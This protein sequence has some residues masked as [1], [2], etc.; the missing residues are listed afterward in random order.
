MKK[1]VDLL[2]LFFSEY[3]FN[4]AIFEIKY[5]LNRPSTR[6]NRHA[7]KS[8]KARTLLKNSKKL[9]LGCGTIH[10]ENFINIDS[11]KLST[12]DFR[13][14]LKELNKYFPKGEIQEI[15]LCHILEHFSWRIV[16]DYLRNFYDLLQKGGIIRISVPDLR[17]IFEIINEPLADEE[18]KLM[19]GVLMGG[20][21]HK[22]N[23]HYSLFWREYLEKELENIGFINIKEYVSRPHIYGTNI[24][25][26][27]SEAGFNFNKNGISLNIQAE[28]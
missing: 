26:A 21:D 16:Q 28:K 9:H 4:R 12:I 27:S 5:L 14:N 24:K 20:Q 8:H 3:G 25:D 10:I 17:K 15:Y 1:L 23:V 13:C 11:V 19:Q 2:K 18:L 7:I 22:H 6:Y